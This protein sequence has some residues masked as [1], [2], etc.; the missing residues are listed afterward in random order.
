MPEPLNEEQQL[1]ATLIG[2][3]LASAVALSLANGIELGVAP[4]ILARNLKWM[5]AEL[6]DNAVKEMDRG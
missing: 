1:A 6:V 5:F 2:L 4:A 3:K